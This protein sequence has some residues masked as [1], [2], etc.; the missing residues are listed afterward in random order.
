MGILMHNIPWMAFNIALA[1]IPV[2]LGLLMFY[3]KWKP[4]RLLISI[5]WLL[6]LPNTVYL[7]TDL[8][9]ISKDWEKVGYIGKIVLFL[10]YG[11]LGIIGIITFTLA[12][13]AFDQ[14]SMQ[15]QK[16]SKI[17]YNYAILILLC[18][19]V[20]F[21]IVLGRVERVHS[22]YVFTDLHRVIAASSHIIQTPELT[23]L[24][25]IWG[26]C[27][28]CLYRVWKNVVVAFFRLTNTGS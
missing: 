10:Q 28:F 11:L 14:I 2:I 5:I 24:A 15:S 4:L 9:H 8:M 19:L 16:F 3:I 13:Y 25:T 12:L 22:W 18:L 17:K 27:G 20:G 23:L 6:F 1:L 21:G 7:L 26:I